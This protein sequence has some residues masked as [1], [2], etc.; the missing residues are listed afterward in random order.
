MWVSVICEGALGGVCG[1]DMQ[2]AYACFILYSLTGGVIRG[3]SR[4]V[5]LRGVPVALTEQVGPPCMG[6]RQPVLHTTDCG[7]A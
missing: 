5:C 7:Q 2:V 6:S 3:A 4:C 1:L